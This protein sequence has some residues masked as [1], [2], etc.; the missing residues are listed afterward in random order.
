MKTEN[1]FITKIS[2]CSRTGT[3]T[4]EESSR[5]LSLLGVQAG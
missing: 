1:N 4:V 2:L 5:D 3:Q